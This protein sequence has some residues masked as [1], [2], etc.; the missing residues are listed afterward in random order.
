MWIRAE[1]HSAKDTHPGH[2]LRNVSP[3]FFVFL[4]FFFTGFVFRF[5][6][7]T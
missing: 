3:L 6:A 2:L 7:V 1:K 5:R 4:L